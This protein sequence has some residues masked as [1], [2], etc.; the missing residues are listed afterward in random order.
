LSAVAHAGIFR[1]KQMSDSILHALIAVS[2]WGDAKELEKVMTHN[3]NVASVYHMMGGCSYL[4]DA[5]FDNKLQLEEWISIMK[6]VKLPSGVPAILSL[7]TLKIIDVYKQKGSF[8]L[9]NY[10]EIGDASHFFMYLDVEGSGDDVT[11]YVKS[12][13]LVHSMLHIQGD[14]SFILE[15]IAD[16]YSKY[17]EMLWMMKSLKSV[18]RVETQEVIV[19]KKYRNQIV[20]EHGS[21]VYPQEDIRQ[22]FTL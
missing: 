14:H 8:D 19:V 2:N 17:K 3:G 7:R 10:R 5:N 15:V 4:L 9:K 18:R 6:G 20:D 13:D 16:S 22:L 21:L 1:R 12:N 11:G